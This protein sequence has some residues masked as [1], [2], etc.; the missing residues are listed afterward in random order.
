MIDTPPA[1]TVSAP[2][3]PP[4]R[5]EFDIRQGA[6]AEERRFFSDQVAEHL[7]RSHLSSI[8]ANS[9][10]SV[11]VIY[12]FRD[13]I[14]PTDA[15]I[16]IAI[17]LIYNATRFF[18]IRH[19]MGRT[20]GTRLIFYY[21][22]G[23]FLAG[24]TWGA[25]SM[26]FFASGSI[27]HQVFLAFVVGG[28]TAGAGGAYAPYPPAF[29]AFAVTALGPMAFRFLTIGD[30]ISTMMGAMLLVFGVFVAIVGQSF[31]RTIRHAI[32]LQFERRRL[33]DEQRVI[34]EF[35]TK[36]FQAS[37]APIAVTDL[38]TSV[39]YDVNQ[40]WEKLS[41][42]SRDETVGRRSIDLGIWVDPS[43]RP[44]LMERLTAKGA[45]RGIQAKL[46][47]KDGKIHELLASG[48]LIETEDGP[49]FLFICHDVTHIN[50]VARIKSEFVSVV[51]HELRTPLSS[52]YAALKLLNDGVISKLPENIQTLI[53]I[54]L[55]NA[56][57][58]RT[59]VNSILDLEKLQSGKMIF[60]F[61]RLDLAAV[62]KDAIEQNRPFIDES[63]L[64]VTATTPEGGPAVRGDE[65]RLNQVI[66]N[67]L[68]NAVKFAPRGSE[69]G[70]SVSV[71]DGCGRIEIADE[72]PGIPDDFR[73]RIFDRF[74]QVDASSTR[75]A[76]GSGLGLNICKSIVEAHGGTIDY[77]ST[78]GRGTTFFFEIPLFKDEA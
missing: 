54:A 9:A 63:G 66:V 69:I 59:L 12:V 36:A 71:R 47:A 21:F 33:I 52:I 53:G 44:K 46:R 7:Y 15:A 60:H 38:E 20:T 1:S 10:L 40:A 27:T 43:D 65:Q 51:S 72:G 2:T 42:Y 75:A 41:G 16:W 77:T 68:S 50:E 13:L 48:D 37:P 78:V 35:F 34:E 76:G 31:T 25:G 17:V 4:G 29:F 49:R 18:L 45:I 23:A 39:F 32:S 74:S 22:V 64:R 62:C 8:L 28:L 67:I 61:E 55:R 58:L 3:H 14:P 56:S 24:S 30:E 57:R 73:D 11:V 5:A 19:A 6:T 70:I 26:M